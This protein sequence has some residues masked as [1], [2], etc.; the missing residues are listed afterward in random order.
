MVMARRTTGGRHAAS[1]EATRRAAHRA[2]RHAPRRAR[3]AVGSSR[4]ASTRSW[5]RLTNALTACRIASCGRRRQG[6][7]ARDEPPGDD[8][9]R[10]PRCADMLQSRHG[11]A[12]RPCACDLFHRAGGARDMVRQAWR[13]AAATKQRMP[14]VWS[15]ELDG[16]PHQASRWVHRQRPTRGGSTHRRVA[17]RGDG[18]GRTNGGLTMETTATTCICNP[19][20]AEYRRVSDAALA[21]YRRV[22]NACPEHGS[23]VAQS[24][25]KT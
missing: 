10:L 15:R 16:H 5:G 24:K 20:W 9:R 22:C 12:D 4:W 14:F 25:V 1:P 21:E 23:V 6:E 11:T 18:S 19:A 3:A 8:R 13:P 2:A 17:R 7:E